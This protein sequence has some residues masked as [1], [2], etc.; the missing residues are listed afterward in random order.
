METGFRLTV[1]ASALPGIGHE[2]QLPGE[3]TVILL[4]IP[5]VWCPPAVTS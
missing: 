4:V 5:P 2:R 1:S 3:D